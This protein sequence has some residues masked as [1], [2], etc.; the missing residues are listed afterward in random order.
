MRFKSSSKSI[1]SKAGFSQK[2]SVTAIR[3]SLGDFNTKEEIDILI[4]KLVCG[5]KELI[6]I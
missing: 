5:A 6:G 1:L 4:D 2:A 3:I